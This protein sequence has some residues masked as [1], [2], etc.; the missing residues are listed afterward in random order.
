MPTSREPA[1]TE[2]GE[3]LGSLELENMAALPEL[4]LLTAT[5]AVGPAQASF[6]SVL[7]AD[8]GLADGGLKSRPGRTIELY[9]DA[10]ARHAASDAIA[11][12]VLDSRGQFQHLSFAELD[13]A[14]S[15]CSAAWSLEGL[16]PGQVVAL[17]LPMGIAWVIAFAAALRL[18]LT[19][20]C[21]SSM[22]EDAQQRR[23]RALDPKR[24]VFDPAGPE[25][26]PEFAQRALLV[27]RSSTAHTPPPRAYAP[28]QALGKLFS[29]VREPVDQPVLLS[30]ETAWLWALR[31]ARFA[32]RIGPNLGLALPGFPLEQHQP[33]AILASLLA[34]A[35]FVEL[36]VSAVA[37]NQT[38]LAEP[39]LT[40]L[41]V[42]PELRDTLRRT[43]AGPLPALR[44][45]FR[46]IDEP[47]DW[48]AWQD[49]VSKN[50]L[51]AV[52]TCNLL[53]DAASGGALLIS[54]RRPGITHAFAVPSPGVPF[55]LSDLSG[56]AA[57]ST[58][59]GIFNHGAKP[60]PQAPGW[61]LLVKRGLEYLYGNTLLPRRAGRIYS[62]QEVVEC[63]ARLPGV[64]GAC[65]VPV[66]SNE[67]GVGFAFVLVVFAGA[68]P[69]RAHEA[70]ARAA[71]CAIAARLGRD[72]LPNQVLVFPLHA[73]LRGQQSDAAWC[74]R[75]YAT[76]FLQRKANMPVFQRLTALRAALKEGAVH[77]R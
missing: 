30:A 59:C 17:A 3:L 46:S 18:G 60:D 62:E 65:V 4:G 9:A 71:E 8:A 14:A 42:S 73:R 2:I 51:E 25:P 27:T 77:A 38:L 57:S 61:F 31:D 64:D 7:L 72:F 5:Y 55:V 16:E 21:L 10:V 45:W 20:S 44:G 58:G 35:R 12:S 33:V 76:G 32:Y 34:G 40:A 66:V 1:L 54:A 67:P 74:R 68:L 24:I 56:Q 69:E 53:V 28:Q 52:P 70:L 26:A 11:L 63:V 36:P 22:A 50:R 6:W 23:L 75:Q 29:P 48:M 43:P 47:F 13:S 39:F 15:A 19:V 49:F 37:R 41:G